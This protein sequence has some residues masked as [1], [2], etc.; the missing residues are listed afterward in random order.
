[1]A[2]LPKYRILTESELQELEQEFVNFL[3]VN[4]ITAD[5]WMEIKETDMDA[6]E[7]MVTLFSDVVLEGVL[8][9]IRFLEMRSKFDIKTF[10]C[11]DQ[12]I[13][14]V[15]MKSEENNVDFTDQE[16]LQKSLTS[17]P[18]G[19]KVYTTEKPYKE[20]RQIELFQ[21]IQ[22]G[23]EIADGKMFKMLAMCLG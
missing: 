21:M 1:M 20:D 23:C 12:K 13:V 15:G 4:G 22:T 7:D 17:P 14:L 19:I 11:L 9:K 18:K 8:R 6:A 2:I 3:I 16:F 5:K 10:Q